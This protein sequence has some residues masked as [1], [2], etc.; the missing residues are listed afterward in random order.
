MNMLSLWAML[1]K[2]CLCIEIIGGGKPSSELRDKNLGH[3]TCKYLGNIKNSTHH[4][5]IS[6][7]PEEKV[8]NQE[9]QSIEESEW[10]G[11]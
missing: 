2:F 5:L 6:Y 9:I 10:F 7:L 3:L 11:L 1:I 8:L 4:L